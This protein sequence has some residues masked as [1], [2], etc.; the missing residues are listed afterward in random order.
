MNT[1]FTLWLLVFLRVSAMLAVV[2]VFSANNFPVRLR[3]SLGAMT[4]FLVTPIVPPVAAM[5]TAFLGIILLMLSEVCVGLLL[6]FVTRMVF[7]AVDLAG[8]II[9][10]E[11]G[12]TFVPDVDPFTNTSTQTPG[13]ILFLLTMMLMFSL[14][15]HHWLLIGFERSY[16]YLPVGGGVLSEALL[17]GVIKRSGHI[18]VSALQMSAPIIAVSFIITLVFSVLSRAVPQMN[19]FA[20]SFAFR[21]LGGLMVFGITINLMAQHIAGFLRMLPD[22]VLKVAQLMGGK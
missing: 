1:F 22:D 4:A 21:T 8:G 5:P 20:E 16:Q 17:V 3:V 2:P 13:M 9:A 19:V 12:L 7:F 10:A 15:L 6:G 14:N 18:F 11:I